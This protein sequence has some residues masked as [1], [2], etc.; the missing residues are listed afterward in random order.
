MLAV[1]IKKYLRALNEI[2]AEQNIRGEIG[3]VGGAALC[4]AFKARPSTKDV[5]AVF[6]PPEAI[7]KAADKVARKFDL[8][9][10][11]LNDAVKGFMPSAPEKRVLFHFT[12]LVVWTPEPDYL[13][14]MK[15]I[16]ARWDT[17][18]RDDVIFLI[19]VLRLKSHADVFRIIE[20]Y[21]PKGK[22]PTKTQF[23]IEEIFDKE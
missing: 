16:S 21:Y 5:D 18:D 22:I 11:W 13:L 15:S 2:L 8:S 9:V 12:H 17:S 3:I 10:N 20:S 6:E 4:L 7:R 14:A 1:E 23:F 19:K